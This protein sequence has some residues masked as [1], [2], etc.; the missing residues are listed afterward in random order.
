MSIPV[1]LDKY[2]GYLAKDE[3]ELIDDGLPVQV[4]ERVIRFRALYTYWCRFS[5][6]SVREMVE[7]DMQYNK[8][9]ESQAYD[10]IHCIQIVMGNLQEASKKF[11]RWRVNQ[12]IEEDRKAAK[13]G[14]GF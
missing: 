12:M 13:R 5:S 8:V 3:N 9:S 10:D 11:H 14:P 1:D 2:Q 7:Y 6:K 4:I